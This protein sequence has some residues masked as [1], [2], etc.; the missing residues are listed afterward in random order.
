MQPLPIKL[1]DKLNF[2][3]PLIGFYDAPDEG[4]FD[5]PTKI[6]KCLFAYFEA[7]QKGRLF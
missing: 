7:W 1:D 6:T 5:S 4:L 3:Y 2:E